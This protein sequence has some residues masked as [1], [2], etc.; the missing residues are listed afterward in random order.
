MADIDRPAIVQLDVADAPA[1][2]LLSTE[3]HWNQN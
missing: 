3:A 2:L 1:A